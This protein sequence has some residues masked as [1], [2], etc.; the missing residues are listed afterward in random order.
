MATDV[1]ISNMALAHLGQGNPITTLADNSPAGRACNMFFSTALNA[2][3]VDCDWGFGKLWSGE[4][5]PDLT[6]D[7]TIKP[8]T[9]WAYGYILPA[10]CLIVRGLVYPGNRQPGQDS[11]PFEVATHN[12]GEAGVKRVLFCNLSEA[13]YMY[14]E[15]D[16]DPHLL[17]PTAVLALSYLLATY[18][19]M[20]LKVNEKLAQ[21]ASQQYM[22]HLSKAR[23]N[24][25]NEGWEH[26]H[27]T[28]NNEFLRARL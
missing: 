23:A 2:M 16:I 5:T 9:N 19:A 26:P 6:S 21:Y 13:E 3:M 8:P 4:V 12:V 18:V 10:G 15:R 17:D 25:Q 1:E 11:L 24:N 7:T 27:P 22:L 28:N 20:P 14:T